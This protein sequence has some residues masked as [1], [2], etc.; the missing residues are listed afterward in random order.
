MTLFDRLLFGVLG[1]VTV[2]ASLTILWV[3]LARAWRG[4]RDGA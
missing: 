2:A 4:D 1:V 3:V